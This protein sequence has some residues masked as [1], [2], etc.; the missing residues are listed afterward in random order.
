MPDWFVTNV[1]EAQAVSHP[2]AGVRVR[3]EPDGHPFPEVGVNIRVIEP[4]QPASLYHA[5]DAQE[6]FLVLSGEC[7]A[8]LDGEERHLRAWDFVHCPAGTAHVFV[9]AGDGPCAIVAIGARHPDNTINYPVDEQAARLG[10]SSIENTSDPDTAYAAWG[11]EFTP[12]RLDWPP[13]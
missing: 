5:E 6:D 13:S 10:A 12:T 4:G 11:R 3:F 8:I 1:A 2:R 9:G 7:V